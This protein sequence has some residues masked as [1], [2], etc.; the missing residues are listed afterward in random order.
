MNIMKISYLFRLIIDNIV[1]PGE[2]TLFDAEIEMT[3]YEY[4]HIFVPFVAWYGREERTWLL[5]TWCTEYRTLCML[6]ESFAIEKFG[7]KAKLSDNVYYELLWIGTFK[8][9]RSMISES[10]RIQ[11]KYEKHDS[12]IIL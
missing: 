12:K 3:E 6:A 10:I 9:F 8:D 1:F 7:E 11:Q 2:D 4:D 5:Y